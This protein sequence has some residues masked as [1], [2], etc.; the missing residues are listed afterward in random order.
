MPVIAVAPNND[1]LEKLK[2]NL[3]EVRARGGE[4]IGDVLAGGQSG[5]VGGGSRG[6]RG[7]KED[8]G[9]R[10]RKRWY[11]QFQGSDAQVEGGHGVEVSNGPRV[12]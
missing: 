3:Q 11:T 1:L 5:D 4:S 2:S 6:R 10:Q 8:Y 12:R 7:R 9:A